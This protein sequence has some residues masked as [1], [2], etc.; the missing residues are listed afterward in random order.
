V[1]RGTSKSVRVVF[2]VTPKLLE[3]ARNSSA[4]DP[5]PPNH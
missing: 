4:A 2:D 3:A 5:A 1:D